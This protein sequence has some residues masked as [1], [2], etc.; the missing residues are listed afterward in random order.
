MWGIPIFSAVA[1]LN[2]ELVCY[3]PYLETIGDAHQKFLFCLMCVHLANQRV[4]HQ[5]ATMC[6]TGVYSLWPKKRRLAC[7][8]PNFETIG[9]TDLKYVF[10]DAVRNL[11]YLVVHQAA[12]MWGTS[13]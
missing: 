1:H 13:A 6:W 2:V 3:F 12:T 9:D 7:Y 4:P 8:F 5:A 11:E 10:S